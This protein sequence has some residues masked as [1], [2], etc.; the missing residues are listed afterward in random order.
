MYRLLPLAALPL[1]LLGCSDVDEGTTVTTVNSEQSGEA[2]T[3]I[4][5]D[6]G[7]RLAASQSA[8][9]TAVYTEA[10]AA[11][12]TVAIS[13]P[14]RNLMEVSL[15]GAQPLGN[16]EA[17][18]V[19]FGAGDGI[20]LNVVPTIDRSATGNAIPGGMKAAGPKPEGLNGMMQSGDVALRYGSKTYGP[21]PAL[22]ENIRQRLL[23]EC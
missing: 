21:Y 8:G 3:V 23:S 16:G 22:P 2:E 15:A 7:W 13:C 19:S 18:T 4:E 1:L 17:V 10:G 9:A 12:G 14:I 5:A 11:S 20:A 6:N